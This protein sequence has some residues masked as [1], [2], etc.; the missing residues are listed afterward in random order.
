MT[1]ILFN[2]G[3]LFS[4]ITILSNSIVGAVVLFSVGC[5]TNFEN[6][7]D[8]TAGYYFISGS[9]LSL[10]PFLVFLI[11]KKMFRK[12]VISYLDKESEKRK[13]EYQ[14]RRIKV[15]Y[16]LYVKKSAVNN[17]YKGALRDDFQSQK[18]AKKM[19]LSSL[20]NPSPNEKSKI[21]KKWIP[22]MLTFRNKKNMDSMERKNIDALGGG[23]KLDIGQRELNF[24]TERVNTKSDIFVEKVKSDFP[25]ATKHK[26]CLS[27]R[28]KED[29]LA[30]AKP[31]SDVLNN[32]EIS[33][34]SPKIEE[35]IENVEKDEEEENLCYICFGMPPNCFF[36]ECG[37]GGICLEC[38]I[39]AMKKSNLCALCRTEI[40]QILEIDEKQ[41]T[42]G[43]F[44]V[45]N[46]Y[47]ISKPEQFDTN[48]DRAN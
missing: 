4:N 31:S 21:F 32:S 3:C 33:K 17:L 36:A 6:R 14:S 11:G 37:H 26:F 27:D 2:K 45:V 48:K 12:F 20:K 25:G 24:V 16:P 18:K 1:V 28:N 13:N 35:K 44:K 10:V 40:T 30:I 7:S 19:Q 38:S 9:G 29:V 34:I 46:C 42:N 39:D 22:S 43:I 5:V 47:F 15:K 8:P 23:S 41:V